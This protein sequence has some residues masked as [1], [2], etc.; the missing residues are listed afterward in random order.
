[1][2]RFE[3]SGF[4][5]VQGLTDWPAVDQHLEPYLSAFRDLSARRLQTGMGV[6]PLQIGQLLDWCKL[7]GI[8]DEQDI[9]DYAFYVFALDDAFVE[10]VNDKQASESKTS[11]PSD[12]GTGRQSVGKRSGK[13]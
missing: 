2:K 7:K 8:T 6:C 13:N 3:K 4:K 12:R 9:E 10:F 5:P 1:M 11:P